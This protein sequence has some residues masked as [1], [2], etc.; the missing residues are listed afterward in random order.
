MNGIKQ[1]PDVKMD[2]D[3]ITPSG[4]GYMDDDF[5][6][7]TGELSMPGKGVAKDVWVTRIPK[8][9]Y[10]AVSKWEDHVEGKGDDQ[11][12][13]GE[14]LAYG[15]EKRPGGISKTKP[16]RIFLNENWQKK[17]Q[18]PQAFELRLAEQKDYHIGNAYVFTEKDLPGYKPNGFGSY[19]GFGQNRQGGGSNLGVQDPKARVFK[20]TKYKKAIPKQTSL[21]GPATREYN[22]NPLNTP[23]FT[24]FNKKRTMQAIQGKELKTNILDN[25]HD[26]TASQDVQKMFNSFIRSTAKPKGQ[27]N[28]AAR[29]PKNELIDL[30]HT[31]FDRF[32]YWG[33]RTLKA[34]TKQPEAYLKEVLSDIGDLVKTGPF[35]SCYR[36]RAIYN[37]DRAVAF[38]GQAPDTDLPDEDEEVEMED[39]V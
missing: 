11:I 10:D 5:Y 29:I 32:A 35:A 17:K 7:D 12:V 21:I 15:D 33:M 34:E 31:L 8:W 19:G 27:L 2:P 25:M 38:E 30:L 28:K 14:L 37:T 16:M 23:E 24:E 36:R 18:L 3:A 22:A 13:I 20:R 1:D 6:E 39:V 4:S 9:L 26:H